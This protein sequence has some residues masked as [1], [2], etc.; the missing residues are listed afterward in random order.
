MKVLEY[1]NLKDGIDRSCQTY[2]LSAQCESMKNQQ[3]IHQLL[4]IV[5]QLVV[6]N[7]RKT[8]NSQRLLI[9]FRIIPT[10]LYEIQLQFHFLFIKK[11]LLFV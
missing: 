6:N 9:E 4:F 10:K 7:N 8:V 3:I 2:F 5:P 1:T 11:Q